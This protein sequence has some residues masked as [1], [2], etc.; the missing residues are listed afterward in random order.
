MNL[1]LSK[2]SVD[3]SITNDSTIKGTLFS[4]ETDPL[5]P[6]PESF[7]MPNELP[8]FPRHDDKPTKRDAVKNAKKRKL[9]DGS[10]FVQGFLDGE[11]EAG[12]LSDGTQVLHPLI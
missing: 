11:K 10:R 9:Y 3:W 1:L 5:S 8:Q 12:D 7:H 6:G 2:R 4:P